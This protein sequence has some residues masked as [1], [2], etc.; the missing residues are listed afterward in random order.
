MHDEAWG[1]RYKIIMRAV[2]L[3]FGAALSPAA[4]IG[5]GNMVVCTGFMVVLLIKRLHEHTIPK[6][7]NGA[8]WS[9]S[10]HAE[11]H[12]ATKTRY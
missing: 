3:Y 4:F 8:P 6:T 11:L 1:K 10:A 5:D 9:R 7:E 2:V 12:S